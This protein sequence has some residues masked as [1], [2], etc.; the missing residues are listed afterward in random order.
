MVDYYGV[1]HQLT[2]LHS[3]YPKAR[4]HALLLEIL[5]RYRLER[6]ENGDVLAACAAERRSCTPT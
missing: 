4:H 6:R 1:D 5:R 2:A 3:G